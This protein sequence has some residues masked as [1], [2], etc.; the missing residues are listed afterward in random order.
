V[1]ASFGQFFSTRINSFPD[2]FCANM[3]CNVFVLSYYLENQSDSNNTSTD[4]VSL[5]KIHSNNEKLLQIYVGLS[6]IFRSLQLEK[7]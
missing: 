6:V 4:I 1:D 3:F 5:L 7:T 2:C